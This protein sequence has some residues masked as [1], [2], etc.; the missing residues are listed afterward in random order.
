[1]T[2][3]ASSPSVP[4]PSPLPQ[5]FYQYWFHR[6]LHYGPLYKNI[7][8]WHH[9]FQAPFGM[10]AEYAHPAE[11]LILGLGTIG[12]PLAYVYATADLHIITVYAW[13]VVR[14]FQTVDAHSGYDFP[15]SLRNWFPLWAGAFVLGR[16]FWVVLILNTLL[17][18]LLYLLFDLHLHHHVDLHRPPPPLSL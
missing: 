11:T 10:A 14:L 16:S 1:M 18:P 8:K 7:H 3:R 17:P 5:D 2:T 4:P 6:L 9:E 12:G 15:W 13:L